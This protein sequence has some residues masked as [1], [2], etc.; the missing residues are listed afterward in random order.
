[1]DGDTLG[2]ALALSMALTKMNKKA[3][4]IY[5]ERIPQS[6]SVLSGDGFLKEFSVY[7][8]DIDRD[9]GIVV[10]V[11]TADPMMLG[12]RKH[13]LPHASCVVNI[14]HH[15]TNKNYGDQI[16]IEDSFAATAEIIFF[17]IKE[18]QVEIDYDIAICLYT[19][20]C[21]DTGGFKYGN[22]TGQSHQ[23]AAE[24]LQFNLDIAA[25]HYLFFDAM[26]QK[27]LNCISFIST[28]ITFHYQGRLA[29]AVIPHANYEELDASDEDYEGLVDLG[30]NVQGT[31]VSILAREIRENE[32]RLNLRSKGKT[33]VSIM[34][35]NNNGGGHRAASGCTISVKS[36]NIKE[37]IVNEMKYAFT[38]S[39]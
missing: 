10:V 9:W 28:S 22:T 33:D 30:R 3:E 24:L 5:E 29:I 17:L 32:F 34:A 39:L 19:G 38:A 15:F 23:I 12:K 36:K 11:D 31:E 7:S 18:M 8:E 16:L 2:S 21:T 14:D 26:S 27:K 20:I 35:K 6:L 13:I 37:F 4:V 1:M 25:L